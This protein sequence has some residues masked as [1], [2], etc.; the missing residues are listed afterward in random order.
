M[1]VVVTGGGTIAPI[2]EVRHITNASSGGFSAAITEACLARGASVIHI[3][4]PS[5]LLPFERASRFR[6]AESADD[7]LAEAEMERIDRVR[8]RYLEVRDRLRLEPLPRGTV[9]DYAATLERVLRQNPID[10]AFLA[11]AVSDY[12]PEPLAGK[13]DSREDTLLIRCR[14][15]AKVIRSVRD[16]APEVYLVGFKLLSGAST[17]ELIARAEE[18]CRTNRADLTVA[19]DLHTVRARRHVVHLVRPGQPPVSLGPSPSL[20]E[21]LVDR[22]FALTA[23][24]QRGSST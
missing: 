5:A 14:R 8:R 20:A 12:E 13:L 9:G 10:V 6:L 21:D 24:R 16:W 11:M 23:E 17:A 19:N 4:P 22:V 2:D 18:G 7:R 15:T 1:K 3:H